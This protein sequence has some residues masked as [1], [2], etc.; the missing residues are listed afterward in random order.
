MI[1]IKKIAKKNLGPLHYKS[2]TAGDPS[3]TS[4]SFEWRNAQNG[5]G[6]GYV[7][8]AIEVLKSNLKKK[9]QRMLTVVSVAREEATRTIAE[10]GID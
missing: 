10:T 7:V 8:G 6:G 3:F 2:D 5:Q 4:C 1:E 9:S